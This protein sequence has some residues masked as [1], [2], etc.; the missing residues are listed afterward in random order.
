VIACD[1]YIKQ[2]STSNN[3]SINRRKIQKI[4]NNK[5]YLPELETRLQYCL[6]NLR[7]ACKAVQVTIPLGELKNKNKKT[8]STFKNLFTIQDPYTHQ[9]LSNHSALS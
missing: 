6:R 5:V 4:Y 9:G 8:E 1:W 7:I 3:V 2:T